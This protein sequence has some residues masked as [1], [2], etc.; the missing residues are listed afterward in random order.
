MHAHLFVADRANGVGSKAKC[1][2]VKRNGEP[3][4]RSAL[5][6]SDFCWQHQPGERW[7]RDVF[8]WVVGGVIGLVLG[9]SFFHQSEVSQQYSANLQRG[10]TPPLIARFPVILANGSNY[11]IVTEPGHRSPGPTS[12]P[13]SLMFEPDHTIRIYGE[14]RDRSGIVA[15]AGEGEIVRAMPG[16][17]Y[18]INSD[19]KAIEVVDDRQRPVFQLR[20]ISY[21]EWQELVAKA[22][23][24]AAKIEQEHS[25]RGLDESTEIA[26][27]VPNRH[28]SPSTADLPDLPP[29][30]VQILKSKE[31]LLKQVEEAIQ[32][33]YVSNEGEHWYV[34]TPAGSMLCQDSEEF[35][36]LR[37][38][39]ERIFVYPGHKHPGKRSSH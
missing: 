21:T 18:D 12:C 16:C 19:Q 22:K 5:A 28:L 9:Y 38:N 26:S 2:R 34:V 6:G 1:Q 20:I 4:T 14:I 10:R 37:L 32:L 36:S 13:F 3:C 30:L 23:E 24:Y 31:S 11:T 8:G 35:D 25:Q 33:N 27:L 15:V 29:E 17:A 7:L 39:M